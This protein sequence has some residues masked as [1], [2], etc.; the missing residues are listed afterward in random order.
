M[1][2]DRIDVVL[3]E[4]SS[5]TERLDASGGVS[6]RLGA[7]RGTSQRLTYVASDERYELVGHA[8]RPR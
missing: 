1:R 8:R 3:A 2:A 7:K 6:L 4:A 5:A